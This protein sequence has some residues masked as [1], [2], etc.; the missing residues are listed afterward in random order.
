MLS[1]MHPQLAE[2]FHY[3][4]AQQELMKELG[5]SVF[6]RLHDDRLRPL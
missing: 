4:L 6:R 1:H 3:R 5:T 2:F